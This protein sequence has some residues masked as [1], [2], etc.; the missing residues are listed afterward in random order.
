[1]KFEITIWNWQE[2]LHRGQVQF[3]TRALASAYATGLYNGFKLSGKTPTGV[4]IV[5]VKEGTTK[6]IGHGNNI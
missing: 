3:A 2:E 4:G 1:M 5:E 6:R